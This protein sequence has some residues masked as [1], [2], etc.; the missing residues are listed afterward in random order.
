MKTTDTIY[1]D[2]HLYSEDLQE[3]DR[4]TSEDHLQNPKNQT[5]RIHPQKPMDFE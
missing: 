5:T 2:H 1:Q 4:I 3:Q